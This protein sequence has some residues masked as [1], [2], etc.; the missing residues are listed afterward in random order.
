MSV[1]PENWSEASNSF[2]RRA[3]SDIKVNLAGRVI[4]AIK[5][6]R[7]RIY[8]LYR[9]GDINFTKDIGKPN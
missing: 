7:N 3:G 6:I 2:V 4:C 8:I 9:T 1:P 5:Y